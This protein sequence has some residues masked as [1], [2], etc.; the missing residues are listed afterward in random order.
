MGVVSGV[1]VRHWTNTGTQTGKGSGLGWR[2]R[3]VKVSNS[4]KYNN[5]ETIFSCLYSQRIWNQVPEFVAVKT[6]SIMMLI[7][8]RKLLFPE[9]ERG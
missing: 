8:Y 5:W 9:R 3:N 2:T 4:E 1:M 7:Y 6:N